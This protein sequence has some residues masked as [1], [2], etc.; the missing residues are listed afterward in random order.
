MIRPTIT[1]PIRTAG[2]ASFQ[3]THPAVPLLTICAPP[4]RRLSSWP[5]RVFLL[6]LMALFGLESGRA[7]APHLARRVL[8][9]GVGGYN[10]G[11]SKRWPNL[12]GVEDVRAMRAVLQSGYGFP[13]AGILSLTEEKATR[14][15]ILTAFRS[16]LIEPAQPGD[17]V[18]FQFCGHGH[19]VPDDNGDELDGLDETLVPYDYDAR[20]PEQN[21]IRDDLLGNLLAELRQKML[22]EGRIRGNITVI[23]DC[24]HAGAGTRGG[25]LVSRGRPWDETD[26]PLPPPRPEAKPD[27]ASGLLAVGEAAARDYVVLAACRSDQVA[28]DGTLEN[29][30][31]MGVFTRFLTEA[32][33]Q[34]ALRQEPLTYQQLLEQVGTRVTG[35]TSTGQQ[36]Q[37]EGNVDQYLFAETTRPNRPYPLVISTKG[38]ELTL[39][40]GGL[41]GTTPGSRYALYPA[42]A[43]PRSGEPVAQAEI[44][45]VSLMTSQARLM[46]PFRGGKVPPARLQT[47]RAVETAHAYGYRPLRVFL[48]PGMP[49]ALLPAGLALLTRQGVT[50]ADYDVRVRLRDGGY[51]VERK[52]GAIAA[53]IPSGKDAAAGLE[54]AL[55]GEWRWQFLAGLKND[56]SGAEVKLEARIVPVDVEKDETGKLAR[57]VSGDRTDWKPSD[58]NTLV[59][60]DD[61][62]VQVELRN[63]SPFP[64]WPA[65]VEL[66]PDGS[67]API[68][69]SR[70]DGIAGQPVP[71]DGKFHRIPFPFVLRLERDDP[72]APSET[73]LWKVIATADP[74]PDLPQLLAQERGTRGP[75]S[76]LEQLLQAAAWGRRALPKALDS[77]FWNITNV[78]YEIRAR[79]YSG[80]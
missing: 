45:E 52:T 6:V 33:G 80:P 7:A 41:H 28:N 31:P 63:R 67:I 75:E 70:R 3:A 49:A 27:S 8:L 22:A 21:E 15:G 11:E 53:R 55:R 73:Y 43:D 24:C 64:V 44:V 71:A 69:P 77:P 13:P 18:V 57:K 58:G 30:R 1:D 47:A 61:D 38:D 2:P 56:L 16:H 72:E 42:G 54:D 34:A 5:L 19:Q 35:A 32:L 66:Q 10:R 23:L 68:Y 50:A 62:F 59:F 48:E 39:S 25:R 26:G 65:I 36:P 37:C 40:V 74:V 78:P 17:V 9:V 79:T 12:H 51:E 46:P 29:G 20:K 60:H 14:A 76:P 4:V